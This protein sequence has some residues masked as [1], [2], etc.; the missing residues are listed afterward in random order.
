MPG[1]D[2][3]EGRP[4]MAATDGG[5]TS[6]VTCTST[7]E[8]AIQLQDLRQQKSNGSQINALPGPAADVDPTPSLELPPIDKRGFLTLLAQHVSRYGLTFALRHFIPVL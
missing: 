6:K 3:Q 7:P 2:M 8:A 4:P 5:I 1:S